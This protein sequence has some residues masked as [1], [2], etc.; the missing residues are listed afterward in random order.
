MHDICT[1][2]QT[3]NIPDELIINVDQT[4]SKYVPTSSVTMAEKNFKHVP[5]QG[6]DDKRAI[7]LTLAE[8]LS[9]DMLPFSNND[10]SQAKQ[11]AHYQLPN[12]LKASY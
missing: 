6:A 1:L 11:A 2:V 7:T 8:T 4:P 12:F 10:I 3:Y 9:G 5:K